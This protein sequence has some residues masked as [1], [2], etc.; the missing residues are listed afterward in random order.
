MRT[1]TAHTGRRG[2]RNDCAEMPAIRVIVY[3]QNRKFGVK[4]ES[5]C[6][7]RAGED[8]GE[9]EEEGDD[10]EAVAMT[11]R[12]EPDPGFDRDGTNYRLVRTE[13]A[14]N[15]YVLQRRCKVS[16]ILYLH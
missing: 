5:D 1:N 13:P 15:E 3:E 9:G 7:G 4:C 14:R 8:W 16:Q 2:I 10:Y 12:A 11:Y 6:Y